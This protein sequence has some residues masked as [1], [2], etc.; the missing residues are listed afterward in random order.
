MPRAFLLFILSA[1]ALQQ[2]SGLSTSDSGGKHGTRRAALATIQSAVA[3]AIFLPTASL[4]ETQ[5]TELPP[6]QKFQRYPQLR[7]IAALGDPNASSGTGADTWGL[8]KDDPGPRGVYL[9]DYQE[10]LVKKG[11]VAPAGWTFQENDWWLEEHGLIMYNPESLPAKKYSKSAGQIL[12]YKRYVVTGDREVT[13]VLTVHDDGRW[14]LQKGSLYDVTHLPCRSAR[15]TP[16]TGTD[17][18]GEMCTPSKADRKNFPVKPGATMPS[19]SD[20]NKQDYA[21]LFVLGEEVIA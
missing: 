12:P 15:Y 2:S 16:T 17:G 14:E 7:F 19:V 20:C 6:A 9:R 5:P 11:G 21:V 8:W 3:S 1:I 18:K 13:T 4:A 10:K